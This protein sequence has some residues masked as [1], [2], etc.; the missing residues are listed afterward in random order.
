MATNYI[1]QINNDVLNGTL[2]PPTGLADVICYK[3]IPNDISFGDLAGAVFY[4]RKRLAD[5]KLILGGMLNNGDVF[6]ELDTLFGSDVI[7]GT[8][9]HLTDTLICINKECTELYIRSRGTLYEYSWDRIT[10]NAGTLTL[11]PLGYGYDGD[12]TNFIIYTND[13]RI[14]ETYWTGTGSNYHWVMM[15]KDR[16]LK[17]DKGFSGAMGANFNKTFLAKNAY[18]YTIL[19][20]TGFLY[21]GQFN[22]ILNAWESTVDI[23]NSYTE[24]TDVNLKEFV[25]TPNGNIVMLYVNDST[26][27]SYLEWFHEADW[28]TGTGVIT[29]QTTINL[30]SATLESITDRRYFS[31]LCTDKDSNIYLCHY[32]NGNIGSF[33]LLSA[34]DYTPATAVYLGS[35]GS[36]N[37]FNSDPLGFYLS[38]DGITGTV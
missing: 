12:Y 19:R 7:H 27:E 23:S 16:T 5:N 30:T 32:Y 1:A 38:A 26:G 21:R 35:R 22:T 33:K 9:N 24:F 20:T 31:Q 37:I 11:T 29:F 18:I 3:Y 17:I 34:S 15:N 36:A 2:L 25:V 8:I 14:I 28:N 6:T 13:D 10:I 4:L